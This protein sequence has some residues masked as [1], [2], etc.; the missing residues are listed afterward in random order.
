[1][2]TP[3]E[4]SVIWWIKIRW[5]HT[6][7]DGVRDVYAHEEDLLKHI[8]V[9]LQLA[10]SQKLSDHLSA[11]AFPLQQEVSHADGRVRDET[12]CD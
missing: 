11:Q 3:L 5:E 1:M 6:I 7:Q 12:T 8:P 10:V 9:E 4:H 2:P